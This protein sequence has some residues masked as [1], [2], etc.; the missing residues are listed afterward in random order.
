[1]SNHVHVFPYPY[2][3]RQSASSQ[4]SVGF[5]AVI[6]SHSLSEFLSLKNTTHTRGGRERRRNAATQR[7]VFATRKE[8]VFSVLPFIQSL[9]EKLKARHDPTIAC[10]IP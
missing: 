10:A 4:A 2:S 5:L 1:M 9:T 8:C 7:E 3:I 6:E